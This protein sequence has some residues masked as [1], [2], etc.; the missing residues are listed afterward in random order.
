MIKTWLTEATFVLRVLKKNGL[1]Y[2]AIFLVPGGV[3]LT[4]VCFRRD[5]K[6]ISH[7][8]N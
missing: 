4:I 3:L 7:K 1:K 6:K 8:K 5:Y 2:A